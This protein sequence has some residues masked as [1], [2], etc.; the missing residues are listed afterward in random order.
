MTII[1]A[2]A[3]TLAW[4]RARDEPTDEDMQMAADMVQR[5][6]DKRINAGLKPLE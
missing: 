6:N 1:E 3:Q 2:T 5:W 4:E